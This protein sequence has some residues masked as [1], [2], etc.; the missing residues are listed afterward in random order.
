M[1]RPV[2]PASPAAAPVPVDPRPLVDAT[3][4]WLASL[5]AGTGV[6]LPFVKRTAFILA[7]LVRAD[8][9]I[10]HQIARAAHAL[11]PGAPGAPGAPGTGCPLVASVDRRVARALADPRLD[12][13]P[14]LR[15]VSPR[16]VSL[17]LATVTLSHEAHARA[18]GLP[19]ALPDPGHPGDGR[20]HRDA[21]DGPHGRWRG[22]ILVLDETSVDARAHALV[23]GI[24][25]QGLVLPVAMRT[26]PQNTR[27]PEGEW[28]GAVTGILNDVHDALPPALR[29]HVTVVADRA[30][31]CGPVF[32]AVSSLGWSLV[33]RIQ[34]QARV[35]LPDRTV[36]RVRDLAPHP[37]ARWVGEGAVVAPG[38]G[39][40][41]ASFPLDDGTAWETPSS[42]TEPSRGTPLVAVFKKAGW[43]PTHVVA[44]WPS[45]HDEPLLL[46]T[47]DRPDDDALDAYA[48]RWGIE[49]T[50]AAWKSRGWGLE[51][52]GVT[53]PAR[54]GR[55]LA[56]QA[57]ATWWVLAT[58][59]AAAP[60]ILARLARRQRRRATAAPHPPH[61]RDARD[62]R[63][64]PRR[65]WRPREAMDGL[66]RL[67]R[68]ILKGADAR[69]S[70]PPR[71][72][73]LTG[74]DAP[75][76]SDQCLAAIASPP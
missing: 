25:W 47:T 40:P 14:F 15:Q 21:H 4:E 20:R 37:G 13:M 22:V 71:T 28:R 44:L 36:L 3:R 76:W 66:F 9:G 67:G 39:A 33:V 19:G 30:Y 54:L 62:A 32:D 69:T 61:A 1:P 49:R 57:V 64:A 75:C 63:D 17:L 6:S 27:M 43:R 73:A 2:A 41:P 70:T 52:T 29:A 46:V 31:G 42:G 48:R 35:R 74:W 8:T 11:L 16:A 55:L 7:G 45:G 51:R 34:G 12:P 10:P 68:T 72:W 58:A 24:A 65:P 56:L 60:A 5:V 59:A 53:C 26:W 23:A 18:C 38:P 50:F